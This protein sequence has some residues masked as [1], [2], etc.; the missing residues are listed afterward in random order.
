MVFA[1]T[2]QNE[3]LVCENKRESH[4]NQKR[5][6]TTFELDLKKPASDLKMREIGRLP[7]VVQQK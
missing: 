6:S 4:Q 7:Y 3:G 2:L 1:H 5:I